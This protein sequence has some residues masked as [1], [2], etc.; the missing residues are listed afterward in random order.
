MFYENYRNISTVLGIFPGQKT[1]TGS[2]QIGHFLVY[3]SAFACP[4]EHH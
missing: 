4:G 2:P 3:I 1:L